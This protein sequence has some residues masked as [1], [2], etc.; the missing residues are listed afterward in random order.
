MNAPRICLAALLLFS[1][2][3]CSTGE[4]RKNVLFISI[5]DLRP[6]LGCYGD[7]TAI[8]PN[9]DK[10]AEKGTAFYRAYCQ[11]ALCSPSR[12]SLLTGLRPNSTKVWDLNAHF[13]ESVPEAVTLPQ[14]FKNQGYLTRSI[15]K[16]F[17][18]GGKPSKDPPSW[19]EDPLYDQ[20]R[21]PKLRYA[22]P[23]NLKGNGLKR[24]STES[25]E[26]ADNHY[27]D[28]KVCDS[29]IK[30]LRR[31]SKTSAPFFLAV[32]F[33]KPHLPFNAPKKYW[34]LYQREQ[35][36]KPLTSSH[37]TNAPEIATRSWKELEGY[38]DIPSNGMIGQVKTQELRHGYYACVSYIDSLVGRLIRTLNDLNILKE[39]VICIWG[40]HGY[41]LGEQG[42][43]TKAN[44]Y[45]LSVR[46]PLI[47]SIP[48]QKK[49][50]SKPNGLVELVDLYP[51]ICEACQIKIPPSL[52]GTS[53]IPLLNDPDKEWKNAAYSQFPR[54]R[55]RNRHTS[56]GEIMG[57]SVRTNT[58]R[59]TEWREWK[60]NKVIDI[61]LYDHAT[62]SNEMTNIASLKNFQDQLKIL[63]ITLKE[64]WKTLQQ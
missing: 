5:D 30:T 40:D 10:I 46:V 13:R 33:R 47:F 61:E 63:S 6:T 29:A 41:H 15:G 50:G 14:H 27:V 25:A 31:Y 55:T 17:H 52:E 56:H 49:Q 32:G 64:G 26:I 58:H 38:T 9:I 57:Y 21:D 23:K 39:T 3:P 19:S 59:Y 45:E 51:S 24:D 1:A 34:D 18:G 2:S 35:I 22:L 60:T 36:P 53:F 37:P 16:I 44:N 42:L 4:S 62:D 7:K 54:N 43:W 28:G 11:Q 12:L 8:T 20:V 48:M